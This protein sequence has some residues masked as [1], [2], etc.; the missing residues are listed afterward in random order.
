MVYLLRG[1]RH[2]FALVRA[3]GTNH[4][5]ERR[6]RLR[7]NDAFGVV[8]LLNRRAENARHANAI[9]A[10]DER[11]RFAVF[12]EEGRVHGFRIFRAELEHMTDLNAA[13]N[14][15][16]AIAIRRRVA[17][18]HIA[19]IRNLIRL[20]QIA[21]PVHANVVKTFIVRTTDE[22]RHIRHRA[23]NH[24]AHRQSR[25]DRPE[26]ARLGGKMRHDFGLGGKAGFAQNF[27]RLDFV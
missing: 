8:V 10:H 3:H 5:G 25:R 22:I 4:H 6:N 15:Q 9:A 21:P 16:S 26:V 12:I 23:I 24:H 11:L 14:G 7:P 27:S 1:L 2:R 20:R 17:R 19:Q 13:T 18:H